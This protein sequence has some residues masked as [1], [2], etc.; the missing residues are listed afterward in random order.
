MNCDPAVEFMSSILEPFKDGIQRDISLAT[1]N[2]ETGEYT[3]YN[4]ENL[5]LETIPLAA[6]SSGS[7]PVVFQPRN[8]NGN[9]YMDGGTVYNVN[10]PSA[11]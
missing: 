10:I 3:I 4:R 7:I 11:I 5:T 1:V 6:M 9:L 8:F 2:I